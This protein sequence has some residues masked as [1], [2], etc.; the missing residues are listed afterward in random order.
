MWAPLTWKSLDAPERTPMLSKS[1]ARPST[2]GISSRF[3]VGSG[4][5]GSVPALQGHKTKHSA[6]KS[7]RVLKHTPACLTSTVPD[8]E[9]YLKP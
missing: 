7:L 3:R 4:V 9:G 1:P 2:S 6:T 5:A 8:M